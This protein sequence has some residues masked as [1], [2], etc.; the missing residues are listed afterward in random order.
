LKWL[1]NYLIGK[2]NFLLHLLN[3]PN[4]LEHDSFT[5]LLGAVFHLAE[6]L[7]ARRQVERLSNT[8]Y[9]HLSGDIHRVYTLLISEWLDYMHHL[10]K[11]YP[12]L[13]S[14]AMRTNPFDPNA[15]I[16]VTA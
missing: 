8:D 9:Q 7:A 5:N 2:R 4:L 6:E 11:N 13:F 16:Y 12:Y 10:K 14:L 15:S 3:N 1:R